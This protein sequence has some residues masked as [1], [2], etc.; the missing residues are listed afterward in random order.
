[1]A[2]KLERRR[3]AMCQ[4]APE[5]SYIVFALCVGPLM[6]AGTG[7]HGSVEACEPLRRGVS[8][9]SAPP[10]GTAVGMLSAVKP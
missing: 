7:K 6:R 2:L 3:G 1:M 4:S 8:F 5:L 10:N 9:L